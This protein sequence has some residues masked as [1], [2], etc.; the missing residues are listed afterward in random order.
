ML[1]SVVICRS[2]LRRIRKSLPLNPFADP[3]L[4]NPVSSIFYKNSGGK[5]A[6]SLRCAVRIPNGVAGR[7]DARFPSRT[8][9][10]E[11][12]PLECAVADRHRVLQVFSR[13][14]PPS[15]PLEATLTRM[16]IGVHSKGFRE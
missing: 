16:L 7:S 5:G 12:T 15:S 14:R 4:L 11:V 13:D 2:T 1:A 9:L 3:H 10:R 8:G 6:D